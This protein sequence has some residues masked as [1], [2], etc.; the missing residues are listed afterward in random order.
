M[1]RRDFLKRTALAGAATAL[2]VSL[3]A[4]ATPAVPVK[5]V[6]AGGMNGPGP[7]SFDSNI[8]RKLSRI[9]LEKFEA[10]R[11][12]TARHDGYLL[13]GSGDTVTFKRPVGC[14]T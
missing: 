11:V 7:G 14:T 3:L 4:T 1:K 5:V 9:F 13:Q 2:P 8:T 10:A 12:H 6:V